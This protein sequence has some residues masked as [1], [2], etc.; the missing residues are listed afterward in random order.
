MAE[1]LGYEPYEPGRTKT[2][3]VAWQSCPLNR[4]YP[5]LSIDAIIARSTGSQVA[6]RAAYV[7]V[8]V[9][10]EG[11]RDVLGL[12]LSLSGGED[13]KQWMT[14]LTELRNHGLWTL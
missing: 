6:N 7:A 14:M 10:L 13:A 3:V 2:R 1:H 12:W 4:V 5:V 8:G 9:N 11:E